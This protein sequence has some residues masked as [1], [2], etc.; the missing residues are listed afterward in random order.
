MKDEL[1]PHQIDE[2]LK[3]LDDM[4]EKGPW[5]ES[6]F[7]KVIGKNIATIRSDFLRHVELSERG[8]EKKQ[9]KGLEK[10]ADHQEIYISLYSSQGDR[11]SSWE[12]IL[13]NLPR[14]I[15]SRPIYANETDVVAAL[16]AK[17]N[18]LND[19]YAA[20]YINKNDILTIV[21]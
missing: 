14:Q 20:V 7:L 10:N 2:I 13:L 1:S 3:I 17:G 4:L 8:D 21:N 11:I 6:N 5:E 18:S 12:R 16:R 15:I 19:A 9:S